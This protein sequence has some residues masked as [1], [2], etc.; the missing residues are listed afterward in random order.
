MG[1]FKRIGFL[2]RTILGL[3]VE[4]IEDTVPLERRLAQD[5]ADKAE[6]FK[7]MMNRAT[8]I[9]AAAEGMVR[10]LA[11]QR[12]VASNLE[13]EIAHHV[14][15]AKT[16]AQRGDAQT[17]KVE[18]DAATALSND[19]AEAQS[20]LQEM[21]A[22]VNDAL[23]DKDAARVMVLEQ[24]RQLAQLAQHDSRLIARVRISQM[25]QQSTALKEAM[26][27][28]V[29]GDQSDIRARAA[30][31]ASKLADRTKS[32]S[33]IVDALWQQQKG[34]RVVT[35]TN[36]GAEI[37]SRIQKEVG[38]QPE[39]AAEEQTAPVASTRSAS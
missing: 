13:Q 10:Q 35:T 37:L 16:A 27:N 11:E 24:S 1:I 7:Q 18:M 2:I 12:V 3:L 39:E 8:D 34:K 5:R 15:A 22:S 26:L 9:G 25:R 28:L 6:M 20:D 4:N 19:L 23:K 38:Y 14:R 36:A 29:P 31:Q 30:A 33:E 32:R 17:E 21:E